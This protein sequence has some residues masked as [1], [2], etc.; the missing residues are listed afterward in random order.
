MIQLQL[1]LLPH[2]QESDVAIIVD[3]L[4][5]TTTSAVLMARG[6]T[7]LYVVA[8]ETEAR[9][10]AKEKKALLLGERGGLALEGF[11]GGNSPLEYLQKNLKGKRAVLCTSNGSKAVEEANGAKHVLLGSTVNAAAVASEA[12]QRAEKSITILCAGLSLHREV[13]LEDAL[14]AA[15]IAREIQRLTQIDLVGDE[16]YLMLQA[17]RGLDAPLAEQFRRAKHG[18][19]VLE[20]GFE[21]DLTFAAETNTLSHVAVR[22]KRTPALFVG[23]TAHLLDS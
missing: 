10:L 2:S 13:S 23:V 21:K 20:L 18:Q 9:E 14:G 17:L 5:M 16:S 4:R 12:L 19:I 22:Q 8:G 15:L 3:V 1:S 11:D 7:E 6:L